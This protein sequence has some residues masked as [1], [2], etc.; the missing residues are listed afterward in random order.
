MQLGV[1]WIVCGLSCI[2]FGFVD[3]I[4][5]NSHTMPMLIGL[6]G[7]TVVSGI[8][9]TFRSIPAIFAGLLASLYLFVFAIPF[10]FGLEWSS[11]IFVV[12]YATLLAQA[13]R[14]IERARA[15]RRAG[16]GLDTLPD[17]VD[18]D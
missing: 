10:T 13:I 9:T 17:E 7:L 3:A 1:A 2:G 16:Y 18:I 12:G 15:I 5:T 14:I 11:L 4:P 8:L 6:G